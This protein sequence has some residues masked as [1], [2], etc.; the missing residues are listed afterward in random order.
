MPRFLSIKTKNDVLGRH[1]D[2]KLLRNVAVE[3]AVELMKKD[4][5]LEASMVP[6]LCARHTV[7]SAC[8]AC[9]IDC[10]VRSRG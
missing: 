7:D 9:L 8:A 2:S 3:W 4:Q 10:R 1:D 6:Y 5:G